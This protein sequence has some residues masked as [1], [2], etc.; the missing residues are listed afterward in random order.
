MSAPR[1]ALVA[2]LVLPAV[3]VWG[4]SLPEAAGLIPPPRD[5]LAHFA[6]YAVLAGVLLHPRNCASNTDQVWI[7]CASSTFLVQPGGHK[8]HFLVI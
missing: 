4:N 8:K 6:W 5:K 1:L 2:A 3:Y 7:Q